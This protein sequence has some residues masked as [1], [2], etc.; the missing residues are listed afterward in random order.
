[1]SAP[2]SGTKRRKSCNRTLSLREKSCNRIPPEKFRKVKGDRRVLRT[3]LP[4]TLDHK[5]RGIKSY[6]FKE[7]LITENN[8]W[9]YQYENSCLI[10]T[11]HALPQNV[12]KK[13]SCRRSYYFTIRVQNIALFIEKIGILKTKLFLDEEKKPPDMPP[14]NKL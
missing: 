5:R 4:L 6:R 12:M 10:L 1:M 7:T 13:N 3:F 8:C 11:F 14:I 2:I 9:S